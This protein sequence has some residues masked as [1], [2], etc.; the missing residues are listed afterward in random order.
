MIAFSA[1]W[2]A[3]CHFSPRVLLMINREIMVWAYRIAGRPFAHA[4]PRGSLIRLI[5]SGTPLTVGFRS[6]PTHSYPEAALQAVI[7]RIRQFVG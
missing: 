1:K 2:C 6:A 7:T 5:P 4:I 3:K